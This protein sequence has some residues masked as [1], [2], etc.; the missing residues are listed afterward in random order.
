MERLPRSFYTHA[1]KEEAVSLVLNGGLSVA[2]V[3]RQLSLSEQTLRNWIKKHK[4]GSL[5][6]KSGSRTVTE[7]EAEVSRL[8]KELS[9]VR[10]E[11]EILKKA[12]GV[13]C[14][15]ASERYAQV[16]ALNR[17]NSFPITAICKTLKVSRSS[18]YSWINRKASKRSQDD[19]KLKV[20]IR[21]AHKKGRGTYGVEKLQYEL[22]GEHGIEV[23]LH[24]IKRL[25]KEMGLR[26][27]QVKK[28]KAT[29]NSKH[30]HPVAPN[31]L[32]QNFSV[33]GPCQV[34]VSDITYCATDE[35]WLYLAG[36]K[37]LWNKEIVGYA[38]SSRMTQD[39][40]GRALFRA[41]TLKRPP[42]GI[43]HHSDRGAQYCSKN[44]RA[45][46]EQF[47]FEVSMSRKGNCYDNAPME[48]FFGTLKNEL[49]HHQKYS[50]RQEAEAD[51]QE[52]IEIFYN[53]VR[54]HA[55]LGNLSP[56]A[57]ARLELTKRYAK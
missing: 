12:N 34:W 32:N 47:G 36:I 28:F 42:V 27:K 55:S 20:F 43:I 54:R 3:S 1:F 48:S 2:E 25:R 10:L 49:V 39:L 50:T 33:S 44:Y 5:K 8:K 18:Y 6:D 45:I 13:P 16:E 56:A 38:M 23:S 19:E 22:R 9:Q 35:G 30:N 11:R 15:R 7:L 37:D 46:L 26:C 31:L 4:E 52:Y 29:T 14:T 53:R 21:M 51:I 57:Y 17:E 24:R 40:V 41:V